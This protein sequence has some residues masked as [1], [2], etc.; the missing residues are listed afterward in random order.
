MFDFLI[1]TFVKDYQNKDD[2]KVRERYGKFSGA[3]GIVTN[4]LLFALKMTAG[5]VFHSI[6]ITADAI[7][8]LSDS[9]SSIVTLV[10]FKLAGKPADEEHPYGHARIEY[11]SGL[12]VSSVILI[13]GFQ[14]VQSSFDKILN[15]QEADFSM[16]TFAVLILSI[17][18]KIWQGLFYKKVGK[19]IGSSAISATAADSLNDVFATSA[20]LLGLLITYF[21]G[22]NLDGYMGVI[23]AVVIMIT[24]VR[25]IMETSNPLLGMAPSKELVD[26]IYEKII[27]YDGILGIHDLHVHNYGPN[28]RF[29]SVHCEVAAEQ[30]I[31]VSHDI[32]DNIERDFLKDNGIHLVI[33]LDP[34]VTGDERTNELKMQVGELIRN[35]SPKI[36][37]HDFRVVWGTTHSNLIFDV[38]VSFDFPLRDAELTQRISEEVSKLDPSYYVVLTVDHDYV[39]TEEIR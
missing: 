6:A 23:V 33:H 8:N 25:L 18:I 31:M 2:E 14:L 11:L 16:L 9:G 3:V 7:N 12:I 4:I 30:D 38:S 17:L 39:P 27:S 22:F 1:K 37:M 20:V 13:V 15:P 29:A 36:G 21:T 26:A 35:I 32:I 24:G 19:T 28:R 34:I 5:I 10:G